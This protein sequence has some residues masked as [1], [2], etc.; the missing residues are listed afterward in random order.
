MSVDQVRW[1]SAGATT[2]SFSADTKVKNKVV[3]TRSGRTVTIDDRVA[4][5][6]GKN[7]KQV[8]GDK[9]RRALSVAEIR[10]LLA[11]APDDRRVVYLFL[12]YTG[13]RRSEAESRAGAPIVSRD[14]REDRVVV[15]DVLGVGVRLL[16]DDVLVRHAERRGAIVVH[17]RVDV[18]GRRRP[19]HPKRG[20]T[21]GREA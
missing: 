16:D 10:A 14:I 5:K 11:A 20:G 1:V 19:D 9:T 18:P 7:C 13:L 2:V 4:V 8:K 3:I 17:D 21:G 15:G 6:P 12:V